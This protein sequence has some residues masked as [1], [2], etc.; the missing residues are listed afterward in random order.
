MFKRG[1]IVQRQIQNINVELTSNLYCRQ[2]DLTRYEVGSFEC[3]MPK[4][5]RP[6]FVGKMVNKILC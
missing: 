1:K 4:R 6:K 5:T 3:K 2:N